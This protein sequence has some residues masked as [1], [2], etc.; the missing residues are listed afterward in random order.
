MCP[1]FLPRASTHKQLWCGCGTMSGTLAE[2]HVASL[3][4]GE[5]HVGAAEQ[6]GALKNRAAATGDA[7]GECL[8]TA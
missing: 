8:S 1:L 3:R 7:R 2:E 5:G 6:A 4:K